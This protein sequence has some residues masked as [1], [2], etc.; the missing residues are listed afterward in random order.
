M[1]LTLVAATSA[2]TIAP[3]L[4]VMISHTELQV[5]DRLE[6]RVVARGGDGLLWGEPQVMTDRGAWA[7]IDGPRALAGSAPPA[8][9]MTIAPLL[10]G[11]QAL[12]ELRATVRTADGTT[13]QAGLS[14]ALRVTIASVLPPGELEIEPAPLR[15]PI[16]AA[17]NHWYWMIPALTGGLVLLAVLL[18]WHLR[19]SGVAMAEPVVAPFSELTSLVEALRKRIGREPAAAICDR[20]A[21]GLRCFLERRTGEPAQE[22]TSY[23][24]RQTARRLSWPEV[25]QRSLQ[26]VLATVDGVRFARHDSTDAELG[27]AVEAA[28]V[29]GHEIETHLAP[30]ELEASS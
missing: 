26:Q 13:R 5:G 1:A 14:S 19:R 10:V 4:D 29:V 12:P 6:L 2:G 23:E 21:S 9:Q 18:W 20:L 11:E 15:A 22:M 17:G 3:E 8:W 28:L 16:G 7:V 30:A 24:L 25:V 27:A